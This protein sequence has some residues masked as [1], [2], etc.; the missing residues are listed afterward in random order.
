MPGASVNPRASTRWRAAPSSVPTATMRPSAT[1]TPPARGGPPRPSITDALSISRSCTRASSRS[2]AVVRVGTLHLEDVV[3][4]R[5]EVARQATDG[6]QAMHVEPAGGR[7]VE[8]VAHVHVDD[9]AEHERGAADGHEAIE[10]ALER[11]RRARHARDADARARRDGQCRHLELVHLRRVL[12]GGDVHLRGEVVV[13]DVDDELA[14]VLDVAQRVLLAV[15]A[16]A[17]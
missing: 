5:V 2:A 17:A 12:A 10:P 4:V 11:D 9:A 15:G 6:T 1:A 16:G 13:D 14:G 7:V 3:D 8:A